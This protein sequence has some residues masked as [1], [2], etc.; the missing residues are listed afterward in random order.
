M[1]QVCGGLDEHGE[2]CLRA[3]A[4]KGRQQNSAF[5]T[6]NIYSKVFFQFCNFF[7]SPKEKYSLI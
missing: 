2:D 1:V 7:F 6:P 3:G 5:C 4:E